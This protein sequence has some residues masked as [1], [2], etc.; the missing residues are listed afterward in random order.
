[1]PLLS[2]DGIGRLRCGANGRFDLEIVPFSVV[3]VIL[4]LRW[5]IVLVYVIPDL[6]FLR[7][8]MHSKVSSPS[9]MID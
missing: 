3:I 4:E 5:P 9:E 7:V 6:T 1:L 2:F 8:C